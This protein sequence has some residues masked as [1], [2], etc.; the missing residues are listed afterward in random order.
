MVETSGFGLCFTLT[1]TGLLAQACSEPQHFSSALPVCKV[2]LFLP[3]RQAKNAF[4]ILI[5]FKN[6]DKRIRTAD[7]FV[8]NESLFRGDLNCGSLSLPLFHPS[9]TRYVSCDPTEH[10]VTFY[11]TLVFEQQGS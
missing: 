4:R 8:A 2:S 9:K 1:R 6:G 11:R 10:I 3:A 7:L 5:I